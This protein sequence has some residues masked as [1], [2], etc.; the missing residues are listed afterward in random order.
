MN[1]VLETVD[2]VLSWDLPDEALPD[3]LIHSM[4]DID[5]E[6]LHRIFNEEAF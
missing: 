5:S 4:S 1:N 6:N 2:R 3:A